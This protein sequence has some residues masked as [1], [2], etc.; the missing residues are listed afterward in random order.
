VTSARDEILARVRAAKAG[1]TS[2]AVTRDYAHTDPRPREEL[3]ALFC[4][5]VADYRAEV[6]LVTGGGPLAAAIA[7]AAARH[8]AA[9]LAIPPQ[10][11]EHWRTAGLELIDDAALSPRGLDALDGVITG[12]TVAIAETGTIALT[13][14]PHEGRRLLSLVP[15]VHICIV[16]AGQIVGGVPEAIRRLAPIATVERRPITFISGPSATS[17]IE[18]QR[19]EGV[20]GPRR[21]VVLVSEEEP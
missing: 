19:V 14:A 17:D 16:A 13:S 4:E 10:L 18:L 11:P 12:C 6:E 8:G 1:A 5:R 2:A 15:D 9:R 20:H 21:L 3:V 7:A